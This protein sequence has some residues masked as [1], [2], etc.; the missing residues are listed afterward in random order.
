MIHLAIAC[1]FA[2]FGFLV[3][4]IYQIAERRPH[5]IEDRKAMEPSKAA[6][7]KP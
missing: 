5:L 4:V 1:G 2:A 6:R 3:M 7:V